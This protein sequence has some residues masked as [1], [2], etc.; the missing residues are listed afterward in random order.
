MP[1]FTPGFCLFF[2]AFYISRQP[3]ITFLQQMLR[4]TPCIAQGE[5]LHQ[6][7][8]GYDGPSKA[9]GR[10]LA[11]SKREMLAGTGENP[12]LKNDTVER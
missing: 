5:P 8:K 2:P 12:F 1:P 6:I 9:I 3:I 4:R 11:A 10:V 7:A